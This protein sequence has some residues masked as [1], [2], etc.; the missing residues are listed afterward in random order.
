MRIR[1]AALAALALMAGRASAQIWTGTNSDLWS[2]DFNWDPEGAP[3]SGDTTN[4][5]FP[6]VN[7]QQM[8]Q[9]IPDLSLNRLTFEDSNGYQIDGLPIRMSGNDA[10]IRNLPG[11][12]TQFNANYT[13]GAPLTLENNSIQVMNF[14]SSV[15]SDPQGPQPVTIAGANG[16][17]VQFVADQTY[18]GGTT[19]SP[20]G[21]LR[22]LGGRPGQGDVTVDGILSGTGHVPGNINIQ[23]D[24]VIWPSEAPVNGAV[25][26]ADRS[27]F[28]RGGTYRI[29][30][31]EPGYDPFRSDVITVIGA[32]LIVRSATI[33]VVPLSGFGAGRYRLFNF[34]PTIFD[35]AMDAIV[36][37]L[38]AGYSS[39]FDVDRAAG[40]VDLVVVPAPAGAALLGMGLLACRRRRR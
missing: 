17:Y 15:I 7:R 12:Y 23:S 4:L 20:G 39:S 33:D 35:L 30:L 2:S 21:N 16:G 31:G 9:D 28:I 36:T 26:T 14:S 25:I 37:G 38:P 29:D 5:Y 3:V 19:V 22:L 24:G 13:L 8:R 32:S 11:G 10:R 40:R 34:D 1:I 18:R 27:L 6:Q